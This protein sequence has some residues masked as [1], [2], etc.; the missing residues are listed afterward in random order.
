MCEKCLNQACVCSCSFSGGLSYGPQNDAVD[1]SSVMSGRSTSDKQSELV[2]DAP[3]SPSYR[4][5]NRARML[6]AS[7]ALSGLAI[8]GANVPAEALEPGHDEPG[9]SSY[10]EPEPPEE[11]KT[12]GDERAEQEAQ[13]AQA[14]RDA[15]DEVQ[16]RADELQAER[17]A[18]NTRDAQV[19][20][21]DS[22]A[23]AEL[24]R[25]A[26]EAGNSTSGLAPGTGSLA[27]AVAAATNSHSTNDPVDND[28]DNDNAL[29][30]RDVGVAQSGTSGSALSSDPI[31]VDVVGAVGS[32]TGPVDG[33]FD[34]LFE[35]EVVEVPARATDPIASNETGLETVDPLEAF[36]GLGEELVDP[37]SGD[38]TESREKTFN[39]DLDSRFDTF[40]ESLPADLSDEEF[41]TRFDQ[42]VADEDQQRAKF[43]QTN[44]DVTATLA[45]MAEAGELTIDPLRDLDVAHTRQEYQLAQRVMDDDSLYGDAVIDE[46]DALKA[47]HVREREAFEATAPKDAN[48]YLHHTQQLANDA[49]A[50]R[51]ARYDDHIAEHGEVRL[52]DSTLFSDPLTR[53]SID[54]LKDYL[55]GESLELSDYTFADQWQDLAGFGVSLTPKESLDNFDAA[56]ETGELTGIA[57]AGG[58]VLAEVIPV[59]KGGKVLGKTAKAANEANSA[60]RVSIDTNAAN[61]DI[62]TE[63]PRAVNGPSPT[64]NTVTPNPTRTTP[65][66]TTQAAPNT[67]KVNAPKTAA[68]EPDLAKTSPPSN[69]P[70]PPTASPP[71]APTINPTLGTASAIA[72]GTVAGIALNTDDPDEP[73][74]IVDPR[75]RPEEAPV[76]IYI[77][78]NVPVDPDNMPAFPSDTPPI[79]TDPTS[80]P[81]NPTAQPNPSTPSE[82]QPSDTPL[83]PITEPPT[84]PAFLPGGIFGPVGQTP[85]SLYVGDPLVEVDPETSRSIEPIPDFDP[86]APL[87]DPRST[88]PRELDTVSDIENSGDDNGGGENGTEGEKSETEEFSE[89]DRGPEAD[90]DQS[91]SQDGAVVSGTSLDVDGG[92]SESSSTDPIQDGQLEEPDQ[93]RRQFLRRA[94][95]AAAATQLP[96]NPTSLLPTDATASPAVAVAAELAKVT[97]RNLTP[98]ELAYAAGEIAPN[99]IGHISD[100]IALAKEVAVRTGEFPGVPDPSYGSIRDQ[101]LGNWPEATFEQQFEIDKEIQQAIFDHAPLPEYTPDWHHRR[102]EGTL[103]AF[104][105]ERYPDQIAK[106]E[107]LGKWV[108]AVMEEV[109]ADNTS[110]LASLNTRFPRLQEEN[111]AAVKLLEHYRDA[112]EEDISEEVYGERGDPRLFEYLRKGGD[113]PDPGST[114]DQL[115]RSL[116]G[117]DP[118]AQELEEAYPG[119][120]RRFDIIDDQ[121]LSHQH[122]KWGNEYLQGI[123]LDDRGMA[124]LLSQN[125]SGLSSGARALIAHYANAEA[126]AEAIL[127][128]N[129]ELIERLSGVSGNPAKELTFTIDRAQ[130]NPEIV[131]KHRRSQDQSEQLQIQDPKSASGTVGKRLTSTFQVDTPKLEST[132]AD[133]SPPDL[134]ALVGSLGPA[135]GLSTAALETLIASN[136]DLAAEV[137]AILQADQQPTQE[138]S[139]PV[140]RVEAKP[141]TTDEAPNSSDGNEDPANNVNTGESTEIG[142]EE[143]PDESSAADPDKASMNPGMS[144]SA[145]AE[146]LLSEFEK[147]EADMIAEIRLGA[148]DGAAEALRELED[149]RESLVALDAAAKDA[150]AAYEALGFTDFLFPWTPDAARARSAGDGYEKAKENLAARSRT[151][152]GRAMLNRGQEYQLRLVD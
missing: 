78:Y 73:I 130:S 56:L 7:S 44:R 98:A 148:T 142:N 83:G 116:F 5:K 71:S 36:G 141:T 145:S 85:P 79:E 134:E 105:D 133:A 111:E 91:I 20:Q 114:G 90:P 128:S 45:E 43:E 66:P 104:R 2:V 146:K 42:Y 126:E 18:A 81:L 28:N 26:N 82:A 109:G 125:N 8:T 34:G 63:L 12:G 25:D 51:Q 143:I 87:L 107:K 35:G 99:K 100:S 129:P 52:I 77:P 21:N 139:D 50:A 54:E 132:T 117:T 46:W 24:G 110:A 137:M 80:T 65:T 124:T 103:E 136:P 62:V 39:T 94:A 147:N 55:A 68:N 93:A 11:E 84:G 19:T 13:N 64:P 59:T 57:V 135:S 3:P 16:A 47:R 38:P 101:F 74:Q 53:E 72:A 152:V 88:Q 31:D 6:L 112:P 118:N 17:D 115:F 60:K 14:A 150:D 70:P 89:D 76:E 33:L 10:E 32:D 37:V 102:G 151:R 127:E 144:R 58:Y 121:E 119:M 149:L 122:Q 138:A 140:K 131:E 1:D 120:N 30:T 106:R 29:A 9:G 15:Q 48:G 108:I 4:F 123:R 113:M 67:Q 27:A 61:D 92:A 40:V 86:L 41:N 95:T 75:T 23:Q 97:G 22:D 96:T 69:T 49:D